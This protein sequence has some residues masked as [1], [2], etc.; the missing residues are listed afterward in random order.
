MASDG[1]SR[2]GHAPRRRGGRW[3][4][5]SRSTATV[6]DED[7]R[8]ATADG[9]APALPAGGP[10]A[11]PGRRGRR[12]RPSRAR[13]G[14]THCRGPGGVGERLPRAGRLGR[15]VR[16]ERSEVG[17]Q[18][19][20]AEGRRFGVGVDQQARAGRAGP[21]ASPSSGAAPASSEADPA[22]GAR[23]HPVRCRRSGEAARTGCTVR[24]DHDVGGDQV[25]VGEPAGV[26]SGQPRRRPRGRRRGRP[27]RMPPNGRW[28]IRRAR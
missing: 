19:E 4:A 13:T 12:A 3:S 8:V 23:R 22:R 11:G 25:A 16:H 20:R 28:A 26:A 14:E 10:P 6:V 1:R 5:G 7:D 24:A 21:V 2:R 15:D 27:R 18:A 17:G 9:P